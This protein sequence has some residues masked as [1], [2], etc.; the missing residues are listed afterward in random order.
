MSRLTALHVV[1][2]PSIAM[3]L[4]VMMCP[5]LRLLLLHLAQQAQVVAQQPPPHRSPLS[6]LLW[7]PLVTYQAT[8]PAILCQGTQ[9]DP[10]QLPLHLRVISQTSVDRLKLD[11]SLHLYSLARGI[12]LSIQFLASDQMGELG[13]R[14]A[15]MLLHQLMQTLLV[16]RVVMGVKPE[17]EAAGED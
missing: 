7:A 13:W 15:A 3:T 9:P 17:V 11:R 5:L 2:E 10:Y 16:E 14:G 4:S 1:P 12:L 6:A 8:A